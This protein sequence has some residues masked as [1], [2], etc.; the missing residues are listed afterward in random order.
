MTS[1][2]LIF[3]CGK[4][5]AGKSTESK[6]VAI[7]RHAVWLS[8]DEWLESLYPKQINSLDDYIKYSGLLKTQL[9]NLVQSILV[10]GIDVVMDFPAN[11]LSQRQWFRSVF[12][13]VKASHHLIFVDV[14]NE[15]CLKQIAKRRDKHPQR[16]A[17]DTVKMFEQV[18]KYF[19]APTAE[20][21][22][23]LTKIV[24]H[25]LN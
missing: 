14:P 20:E 1:G 15:V 22:F 4:M 10:R 23:K 7:E 8:E 6:K 16:V 18:T 24:P 25:Y 3:F 21:G 9:K 11:T 17:T 12:S 5:G 2:S 13:E 19:V